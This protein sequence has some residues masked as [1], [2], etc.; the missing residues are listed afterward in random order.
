MSDEELRDELV[1]VV[2]AGHETTA[3]A[4]AWAVERLLRT[5]R[6]LS[7]AAGVD[8]GRRGRLPRRR[9]SRRRCASRP[10]IVDVARKLT[11]P[12]EIG[13]Y[14]L[15][16]GHA[17]AA[18]DRRAALP[19]GPLSRSPTSSGPSASSTA[20]ADNYAWIP[21]G[22]GVRRCLG[23]AF[24]QYEMRV[25]LRDDPRARRAARPRPAPGA[26][27]DPQHHAGARQGRP[28]G[29][30]ATAPHL[31]TVPCARLSRRCRPRPRRAC[32]SRRA[33]R[34]RCCRRAW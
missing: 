11:A 2:G 17:R 32:S 34:R 24:A 33:G 28:G 15:P 5:P 16:A 27:Q 19:R 3:T 31:L 25:V 8:R 30:G 23:A 9:R 7:A 13:G 14:E 1:T 4:L 18:G 22:G 29:A 20:S 12:A 6:V 21:F 26:G 10:V